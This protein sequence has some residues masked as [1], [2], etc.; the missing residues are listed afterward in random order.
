MR[1]ARNDEKDAL[2][3]LKLRSSLAWGD[4]TEE[5]QAL[6]EA[7]QIPAAHLPSVFVAEVAGKVLGFATV[8]P[9]GDLEA[10]L[11]DLFVAPDAWRKGVGAQL[12][13]EAERRAIALGARSIH[14]V[15]TLQARAFYEACGFQMI[16]MV[17]TEFAQAPEMRK[18][19]A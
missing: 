11:E 17:M 3:A 7:R 15:A 8:L 4:H 13:A 6:P 16:G 12:I 1:S 5:L 14:V 19:L 18:S 9:R 10:E 2:G